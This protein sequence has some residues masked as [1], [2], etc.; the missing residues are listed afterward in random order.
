LWAGDL[1]E[2]LKGNSRS[3]IKIRV[4]DNYPA[5]EPVD[6]NDR[7]FSDCGYP[8]VLPMSRSQVAVIAYGRWEKDAE[9]FIRNFPINTFEIRQYAKKLW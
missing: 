1:K 5:E 6:Y 8:S 9:P 2:L 4:A 7:K 3:G